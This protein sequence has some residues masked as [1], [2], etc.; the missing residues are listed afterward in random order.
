[1]ALKYAPT[2]VIGV[3]TKDSP[4]ACLVDESR[5]WL[6]E[7]YPKVTPIFRFGLADEN[8]LQ[9]RTDQG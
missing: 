4:L 8:G 2:L 3:G 7:C 6:S 1:M 5:A 9:D